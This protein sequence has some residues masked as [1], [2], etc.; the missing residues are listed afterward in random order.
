MIGPDARSLDPAKPP[1][2]ARQWACI[3]AI[4]AL[5]AALRLYGLGDWAFW[6]DE[7]HTWRDATFPADIFWSCN[8]SWYPTSYVIVRWALETAGPDAVSEG[9]LRL[10]FALAGIVSVPLLALVARTMAGASAALLAATLLA[11]DPW[12]VYWSQNARAYA[13]VFLFALLAM[14]LCWSGARRRSLA[15]TCLAFAAALV[16]ITCHPTA[17]FALLPM[18]AFPL[19]R[20]R[21]W[22]ARMVVALAALTGLSFLVVPFLANVPPFHEFVLAKSTP[23]LSHFAQTVAFY[24]RLPVLLLAVVGAWSMWQESRKPTLY[25]CLWLALPL[26]A[27]AVL[28]SSL[29]KATARYAYCALPAALVLAAVGC[30]RIRAAV[31]AAYADSGRWLRKLPG[32]AAAL[33]VCIDLLVY[34]FHYFTIQQGDRGMWKQAAQQ[35]LALEPEG[36]ATVLTINEPT[37]QF[38]L[39]RWHYSGEPGRIGDA[40]QEVVSIEAYEMAKVGGAQAWFDGK[41][42]HAN[43]NGRSLYAVITLPELREKDPDHKLERAIQSRMEL[44]AAYPISVGPKDETIFVYRA[45][46]AK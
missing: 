38:Y 46:A 25:L 17:G 19:L 9:M 8:R 27:L 22:D 31:D 28:G 13:L 44:V 16:G 14:G 23:D 5:A 18:V 26:L 6:V 21:A 3:A 24:F 30:M 32:L 12:H 2:T 45:R 20:D 15:T 42:S 37:M 4:T 29:V 43:A 39:R 36:K 1:F 35:V 40:A 34:D 41:E 33:L 7:A 10:P 11:I